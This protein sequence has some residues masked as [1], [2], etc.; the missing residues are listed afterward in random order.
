M[1]TGAHYLEGL[2]TWPSTAIQSE[3]DT[4]LMCHRCPERLSCR[5]QG[6]TE[7]WH[8]QTTRLFAFR[9]A[10][11]RTR[12]GCSVPTIPTPAIP[13]KSVAKYKCGRRDSNL[14]ESSWAGSKRRQRPCGICKTAR[15]SSRGKGSC[16]GRYFWDRRSQKNCRRAHE[17]LA[18]DQL[19]RDG[20]Y[21]SVSYWR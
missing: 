16:L 3:Q 5:V 1:S 21:E 17:P 18:K 6:S 13:K 4:P 9:K 19:G 12:I 8:S 2:A 10:A 11:R 7:L 15:E 14:G 20:S